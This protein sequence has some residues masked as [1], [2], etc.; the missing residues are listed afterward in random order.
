[1]RWLLHL[2]AILAI[3]DLRDWYVL[4]HSRLDVYGCQEAPLVPHLLDR[5]NAKLLAQ[6]YAH[7]EVQQRN[8]E[9]NDN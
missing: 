3:F 4:L 7:H 6:A 5:I 1:M 9:T 2:E 8:R